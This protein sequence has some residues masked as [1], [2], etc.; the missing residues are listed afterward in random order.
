MRFIR[1]HA[2]EPISVKDVLQEMN[3]SR[4]TMDMR[5]MKRIGRTP[6]AEIIRIRL[7][8]A[9]KLLGETDLPIPAVAERSGLIGQE[10]FS[11]DFSDGKWDRLRRS[12]G[13]IAGSREIRSTSTRIK[14]L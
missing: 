4:K 7:E 6:R 14:S 2:C 1:R 8:R 13:V 12:T 10:V 5:F 3:L 11:H 9:K